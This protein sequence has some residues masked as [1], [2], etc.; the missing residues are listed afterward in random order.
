[1]EISDETSPLNIIPIKMATEMGMGLKNTQMN[2]L[3]NHIL[4]N[5]TAENVLVTLTAGETTYSNFSET[6]IDYVVVG[7]QFCDWFNIV[8]RLR[9]S[10]QENSKNKELRASISEIEAYKHNSLEKEEK[11]Y[12]DLNLGEYHKFLKEKCT[13]GYYYDH[14]GEEESDSRA[15]LDYF[16]EDMKGNYGINRPMDEGKYSQFTENQGKMMKKFHTATNH[17]I[18]P[19][20]TIMK[21]KISKLMIIC[22]SISKYLKK[23][24]TGKN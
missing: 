6:R 17:S 12:E 21:N 9:S 8:R 13:T 7:Q 15:K 10:P 18:W 5:K 22:C 20:Q 24:F 3:K 1:M 11:E 2:L 4:R 14:Q 16:N 23:K 19:Y